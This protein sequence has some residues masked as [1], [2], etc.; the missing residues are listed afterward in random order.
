MLARA[1]VP[2][3]LVL[4][5]GTPPPD[6]WD[7]LEDWVR[8][9]LDPEEVAFRQHALRDRLLLRTGGLRIDDGLLRRGD[10]WVPLTDVQ[11]AVTRS[12]LAQAGRVVAR[13]GPA[14]GVHRRRRESDPHGVPVLPQAA[15]R[16][17][18]RA[19]G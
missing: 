15:A 1:G 8:R 17:P 4:E 19:A 18:P 13:D 9:P 10:R 11:L 3:L 5:P 7:E 12:L 14:G 16:A 2:R 6:E